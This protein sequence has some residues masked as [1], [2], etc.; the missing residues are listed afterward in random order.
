MH[1]FSPCTLEAG[2]AGGH[3]WST[4]VPASLH[5]FAYLGKGV[6]SPNH[7]GKGV[8]AIGAALADT[9]KVAALVLVPATHYVLFPVLVTYITTSSDP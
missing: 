3:V 9:G 6:L 8:V 4:P 1:A 2:A 5:Y 7:C